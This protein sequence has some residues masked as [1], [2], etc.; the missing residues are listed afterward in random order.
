VLDD[1][2]RRRF[3]VEPSRKDPLPAPLRVADVELDEGSGQGLHLPGRGRLAGAKPDDRIAHPNRL[4][5]LERDRAGDAVALV[6]EP[7]HGDP[8]RHRSGARSHGGDGLRDVDGPR[9]ADRLPVA[10]TGL[11]GAPVAAGERGQ[12]E[13]SGAERKPHAWSGVHAS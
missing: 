11:L 12:G 5:R 8:L 4:A 7:E 3:L 13:E 6:E 1:V 2:E 9:L 10:P